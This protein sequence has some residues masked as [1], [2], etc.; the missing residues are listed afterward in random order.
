MLGFSDGAA[1]GVTV[2]MTAGAALGNFV[3]GASGDALARRFP[4]AARPFTNQLSLALTAPLIFLALKAR[5]T[6]NSGRTEYRRCRLRSGALRHHST[7]INYIVVCI[8]P[9][10]EGR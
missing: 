9:L 10:L 5:S 4:N 8:A 6:L 7:L 2:G 3:G 1:T